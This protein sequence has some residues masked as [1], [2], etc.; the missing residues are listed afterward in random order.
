MFLLATG[1]LEKNNQKIRPIAKLLFGVEAE[2]TFI[3]YGLILTQSRTF[4]FE[5]ANK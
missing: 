3:L 2:T 1:F 5:Y 4:Y